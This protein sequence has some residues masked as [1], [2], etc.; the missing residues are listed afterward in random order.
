MKQVLAST[1]SG[2]PVAVGDA[3]RRAKCNLVTFSNDLS[4]NK[5]QF[6]LLGDPALRLKTP[7]LRLVLTA[8]TALHRV[9]NCRCLQAGC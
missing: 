1:N 5:L 8:L 9:L 3:L 4:V 2:E 6:V 7:A